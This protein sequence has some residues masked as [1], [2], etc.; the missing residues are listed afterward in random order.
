MEGTGENNE[1]QN[2]R[3]RGKM[4]KVWEHFIEKRKY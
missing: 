3:K 1:E 2:Q 4:S